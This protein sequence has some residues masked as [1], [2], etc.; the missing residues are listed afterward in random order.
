VTENEKRASL[1]F[2]PKSGSH[3]VYPEGSGAIKDLS[4]NGMYVLDPDPLPDGTKISFSLRQG[5]DDIQLQGIVTRSEPGQGMV[6]QFTEL[7]R[8][9]IR[10]LKLHM[11]QLGPAPGEP[12]KD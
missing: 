1:R 5:A 3:I 10:R 7:T 9:S 6:I 8:E 4:L 2:K 11:A 12:K